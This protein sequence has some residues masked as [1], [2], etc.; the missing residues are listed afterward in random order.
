VRLAGVEHDCYAYD[1]FKRPR[2]FPFYFFK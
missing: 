2:T 1:A